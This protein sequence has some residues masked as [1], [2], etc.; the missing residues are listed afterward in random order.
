MSILAKLAAALQPTTI[1]TT[2][3]IPTIKE[4]GPRTASVDAESRL[5]IRLLAYFHKAPLADAQYNRQKATKAMRLLLCANEE[6]A[7]YSVA[8]RRHKVLVC[9]N[10]GR[11]Y[12]LPM[13]KESPLSISCANCSSDIDYYYTLNGW[14]NSSYNP[15]LL[16]FNDLD[17]VVQDSIIQKLID[18]GDT[19]CYDT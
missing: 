19:P 14:F 6:D 12:D 7:A 15:M 1:P 9:I 17:Y 2:P 11:H 4:R 10:C 13:Y 5:F 8:T 16:I 3:T 18:R